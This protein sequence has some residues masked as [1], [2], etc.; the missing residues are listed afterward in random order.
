MF[1]RE[2]RTVLRVKNHRRAERIKPCRRTESMSQDRKHIADT[3]GQDYVM[4][5]SKLLA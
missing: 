3:L 5:L 2:T 4:W 1:D